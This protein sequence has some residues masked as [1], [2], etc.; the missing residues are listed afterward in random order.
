[1]QPTS[2]QRGNPVSFLHQLQQR[3]DTGKILTI[4]KI[5]RC[6]GKA[7]SSVQGIGK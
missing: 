5:T 4:T 1:M 2:Q 3:V 7:N 6:K